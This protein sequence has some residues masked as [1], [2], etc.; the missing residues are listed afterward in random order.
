[1]LHKYY[2]TFSLLSDCCIDKQLDS[3][4]FHIQK[5]YFFDR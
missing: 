3:E 1:M 4:N 5:F 2:L